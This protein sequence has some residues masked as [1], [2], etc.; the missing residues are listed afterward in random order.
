MKRRGN[1]L[2]TAIASG[3][4]SHMAS[5][6]AGKFVSNPKRRRNS[7]HSAIGTYS[8]FRGHVPVEVLDMEE[9]HIQ[10]GNYAA[11]GEMAGLWLEDPGKAS[12]EKWRPAT[13]EFEK[14]DNV[15]LA[16]DAHG[17]R[18]FFIGGNQ[19]VPL[20]FLEKAG[21]DTG[22]DIIPL[23]ICYAIAYLTE[24]SFN[25]FKTSEYGHR[26]GEETGERPTLLYDKK[27]K[28]LLLEGGAYTIAPFDPKLGASPGIAN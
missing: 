23:G 14:A 9:P 19:Q 7:H 10:K 3:V 22:H 21:L 25:D 11:L 18:L 2:G 8:E 6:L 17:K 28:R 5:R 15:K 27:K 4:V 1:S 24:K 12:P 16:T 13:L 20:A 26:F